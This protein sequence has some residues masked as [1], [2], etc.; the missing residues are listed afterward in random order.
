MIFKP[1]DCLLYKPRGLFGRIIAV[2]TW[3]SIAHVELYRG[4]GYSLASRDGVGVGRY[5]VRASD[6]AMVMR[7]EDPLDFAKGDAWFETVKGQ[8]YGWLDLLAFVGLSTDGRGMVCSPFVAE[9]YHQCGLDA[10]NGEE[11][12]KI[13]PFQF[14][15]ATCFTKV[16]YD[17][18]AETITRS[19]LD[20]QA[21]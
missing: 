15:L 13:A 14:A 21:R 18:H 5:P 17:G 6:L 19:G 10:F 1:G 11:P 8:P 20:T 7:P 9:Y 4:D 3:H 2:K 12:R 16:A